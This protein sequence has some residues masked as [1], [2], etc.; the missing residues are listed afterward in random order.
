M[1]LKGIYKKAMV[2]KGIYLLLSKTKSIRVYKYKN[3][4]ALHVTL[5]TLSLRL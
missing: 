3:T 5:Y 4:K 1:V 2:S